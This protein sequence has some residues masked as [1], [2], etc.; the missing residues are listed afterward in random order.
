MDRS[1]NGSPEPPMHVH[2]MA[3]VELSTD[4]QKP[5]SWVSQQATSRCATRKHDF[6]HAFPNAPSRGGG[7]PHYLNT[8]LTT[9]LNIST[10]LQHDACVCGCSRRN[11]SSTQ[12]AVRSNRRCFVFSRAVRSSQR[13]RASRCLNVSDGVPTREILESSSSLVV[14]VVVVVVVVLSLIHI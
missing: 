2:V 14:V 10:V 13:E 4:S 5:L 12:H 3:H 1:L 6:P 7:H 11:P 9:W 8:G